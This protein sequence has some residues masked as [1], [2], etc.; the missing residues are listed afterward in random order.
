MNWL[1][2]ATDQDIPILKTSLCS[3]AILRYTGNEHA[4]GIRNT[5]PAENNTVDQYRREQIHKRTRE[6]YRQAFPRAGGRQPTGDIW[7]VLAFRADK[8]SKRQPV[9]SEASALPG[10]QGQC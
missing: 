10:E 8:S 5:N 6:Q 2:I 4:V 9:E 1:A 3:R 7:I